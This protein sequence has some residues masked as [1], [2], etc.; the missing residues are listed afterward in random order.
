MEQDKAKR[1]KTA[2]IVG[3]VML[4]VILVSVLIYQLVAI[5]NGQ[6]Q[7]NELNEKIAYYK[8]IVDDS[9]KTLEARETKEWIEARARELGYYFDG[10]KLY[11]LK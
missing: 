8:E 3:A 11:E 9:E 10:D 7:L 5:T 6:R 4:L 2:L 1:I